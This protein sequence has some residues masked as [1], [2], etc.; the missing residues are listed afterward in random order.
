MSPTARILQRFK[1][2]ADP[3]VRLAAALLA[4]VAGI[5]VLSLLIAY[6]VLPALLQIDW[7]RPLFLWD[8][9]PKIPKIA[10]LVIYICILVAGMGTIG[11]LIRIFNTSDR[12]ADRA[13]EV[14]RGLL[15]WLLRPRMKLAVA[16]LAFSSLPLLWALFITPFEVP[17][18]FLALPTQTVL[19]DDTTSETRDFIAD[20]H[21]E[22]L[23]IPTPGTPSTPPL[24]LSLKEAVSVDVA[25]GLAHELPEIYWYDKDKRA[26]E[27][28]RI[29]DVE[30]YQ[31]L[32]S[33]TDATQ[34]PLLQKRFLD[35]LGDALALAARQ[36]TAREK[37]FLHRNR[38]ELERALVLG[39]FFYHHSF[40]FSP[41]V[42]LAQDPHV[43]Y[44]SQYGKGLTQGFAF[45]LASVQEH[46]QF[47]AYLLMLYASY[48]LYLL[49]LL[50][51][52][53]GCGL[54]P[55]GLLFIAAAT[56]F[57]F[58]MSELETVRLGVGLA[59][60]RHMF[61]VV[62]L[63]MLYRYGTRQTVWHWLLLSAAVVGG[64]YWSRE[65]GSL[66]GLSAVGVLL[67]LAIQK[68][69]LLG[70]IPM[71]G[72]L[73]ITFVSWLL[74]DPYAQ[75]VTWA[76]PLGA[77]TP[78]VPWGF[79]T[80]MVTVVSAM[81]AFWLWLAGRLDDNPQNFGWWCVM[82]AAV[83]SAAASG[84]YLMY[85]PRPHHLAP[86]IPALALGA[87]AS[88]A[89]LEQSLGN[90]EARS[91]VQLVPRVGTLV[92]LLTVAGLGAARGVEAAFESRIFHTHVTHDWDFPVARLTSTGE[93]D[94]L[95]Q[96]VDMITR[97]NPQATVDIL[98]PWETALLPL[99]GKGKNGPF[100]L[101]FD[102]LLTEREVVE[103]ADH[104]VHKGHERLFVDTR[105]MSGAYELPLLPDAY[106]QNRLYASVLRV[107][108][109]VTLRD[110]FSRIE[111]CYELEEKGP[112]ISA[113]R[114]ISQDCDP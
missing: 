77:N 56:L 44:A 74:S 42:A 7:T 88:W 105:L 46:L 11:L 96:G 70:I 30:Q 20:H 38:P 110:V 114:R 65:M 35:D 51:V 52:G 63:Y 59:P 4:T 93:P 33:L 22:G 6:F 25:R 71:A 60:W 92:L 36:Y 5:A 95:L 21:L 13:L 97:E 83:F 79:I 47:N 31:T 81:L 106:M 84:I 57:S 90:D 49:L 18:E 43:P 89:I 58:L 87:A 53:R 98:S 39:R 102:S 62:V 28:H 68:R 26:L 1:M 27:V 29:P 101:S 61:D 19:V 78:S 82:G 112:F 54:S 109:H 50:V 3:R 80:A 15:P 113:Y 94:L 104:L 34:R 32:L 100:L 108:A 111:H 37:D 75:S 99:A 17:N 16:A 23:S 55:W 67:A 9:I 85:Y 66:I 69:N 45:V 86:N 91:R 107:R 103:L 73:S 10:L 12:S 40:I 24:L 2:Q 76:V 64:I 41:A 48:P 8:P 72:L 14:L